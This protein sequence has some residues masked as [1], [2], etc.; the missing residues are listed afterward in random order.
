MVDEQHSSQADG[1]KRAPVSHPKRPVLAV[2]FVICALV[3]FYAMFYFPAVCYTNEH[4]ESPLR[5]ALFGWLGLADLQPQWLANVAF[6]WG[7]SLWFLR[8]EKAGSIVSAV[9]LALAL[10]SFFMTQI[11]NA[12]KHEDISHFSQGF[13]L[14]LIALAFMFFANV[15]TY[16]H[17][18]K[19][20]TA[21]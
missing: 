19:T 6:V 11:G 20:S 10:T 7:V 3:C 13:Y 2:V 5:F 16:W 8:R 14:W 1:T 12:N 17:K 21:S 9:G 15:V 18:R 4:C